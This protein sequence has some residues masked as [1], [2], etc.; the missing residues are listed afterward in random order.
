LL[1]GAAKAEGDELREKSTQ[2]EAQVA[3]V[4]RERDEARSQVADVQ[5]LTA[6]YDDIVEGHVATLEEVQRQLDDGREAL[7]ASRAAEQ[8]KATECED[9]ASTLADLREELVQRASEHEAALAS[10]ESAKSSAE[11]SAASYT[12]QVPNPLS[13]LPRCYCG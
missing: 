8:A 7:A 9:L 13:P 1:L 2:V 11:S 12:E 3:A 6:R 5:Q 4:T 10:A